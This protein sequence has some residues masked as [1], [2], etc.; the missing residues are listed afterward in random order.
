[1]NISKMASTVIL[2]TTIATIFLF[3]IIF[4]LYGGEDARLKEAFL[5][6]SGFFGGIATLVAAYIATQL[7][8]DWRVEKQ[9]E[10]N[11]QYVISIKSK[12]AEL[13]S[14]ISNQRT[15][16]TMI[17]LE[18]MREDLK[19]KEYQS[20]NLEVQ[21]IIKN[22]IDIS[23]EIILDMQEI[24]YLKT[25]RSKNN[26]VDGFEERLC[27]L[28]DIIKNQDYFTNYQSIDRHVVFERCFG[29]I[30]DDLQEFVYDD[31]FTYYLKDLKVQ[32]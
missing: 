25:Q 14:Y 6:T 16:F 5:T 31:I 17:K 28:Q 18:L 3:A 29:F 32:K 20:L 13:R 7:F 11:Q 22:I 19:I 23:G 1:M 15:L 4:Y 12:V 27:K 30:T 8:N 26:L 24:N 10:I 9:F 21:Q 2:T